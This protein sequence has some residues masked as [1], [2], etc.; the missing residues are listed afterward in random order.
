MNPEPLQ[1]IERTT[2]VLG[3]AATALAGVLWGARGM[4]AAAAGAVLGAVNFWA[5]RRLGRRAVR[6]VEAGAS[7]GQAVLL[8]VSLILKMTA[9]FALVWI[10]VRVVGL[11]AMPFGL[12]LSAFV[13]SILLV[14]LRTGAADVDADANAGTGA[15]TR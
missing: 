9:L 13:L 6:R 15:A 14:G 12:G 1:R 8:A 10:A 2:L 5:I 4:L 3:V 7:S 11:P